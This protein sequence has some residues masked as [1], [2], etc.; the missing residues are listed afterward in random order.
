MPIQY[1]TGP[2]SSGQWP[3]ELSG[4]MAGARRAAGA[5][6]VG[7]EGAPKRAQSRS[8]ISGDTGSIF[9]RGLS[10]MPGSRFFVSGRLPSAH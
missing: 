5:P 2:Y 4:A 1:L 9:L 3:R 7:A 6:G 8:G 10:P